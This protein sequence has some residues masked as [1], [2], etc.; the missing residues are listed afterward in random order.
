MVTFI[1]QSGK[2]GMFIVDVYETFLF[3][4]VASVVRFVHELAPGKF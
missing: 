4:N 1:F 2:L 3:R